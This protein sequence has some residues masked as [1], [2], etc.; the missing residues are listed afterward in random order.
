MQKSIGGIPLVSMEQEAARKFERAR[1][2][3]KQIAFITKQRKKEPEKFILVDVNQAPLH[4]QFTL[5]DEKEVAFD[6]FLQEL[7]ARNAPIRDAFNAKIAE[8]KSATNQTEEQEPEWSEEDYC[9]KEAE[10]TPKTTAEIV[11]KVAE[12]RRFEKWKA[13][14]EQKKASKLRNNAPTNPT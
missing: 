4:K 8:E 10:P 1:E 2:Y 11:Q 5:N 13:R 9:Y 12:G 14:Q 6:V 7:E 3:E